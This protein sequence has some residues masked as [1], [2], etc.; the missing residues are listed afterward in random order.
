MSNEELSSE[1]LAILRQI[2]GA[3]DHAGVGLSRCDSGLRYTFANRFHADM[4]GKSPGAI[5]KQ[6]VRD[7][8]GAATFEII[9]PYLAR[10]LKGEP[11][12]FKAKVCYQAGPERLIHF[13]YVPD[14]D[15]TGGVVGLF[16][17]EID[18]TGY[19]A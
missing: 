10:A 7:I 19:K 9:A 1:L 14:V 2:T 4:V 13:R 18:I 12:E 6:L 17:T 15:N 3:A 11:V 16:S 8:A 5:E